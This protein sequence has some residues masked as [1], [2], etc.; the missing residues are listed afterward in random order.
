M[1]RY[2]YRPPYTLTDRIVVLCSRITEEIVKISITDSINSSP[3]LRRAN[4]VKTIQASLAIE[5]NTLSIEQVT[6]IVNGKRVLGSMEEICEVRNAFKAYE[7]VLSFDPYSVK[8]MLAAHRILM[9]D[10]TKEA[11]VFRSGGVGVFAGDRIVHMAPPAERV[12]ELIKELL[13]WLKASMDVH[14]LVRSCVFHYEFEFS[15][16]FSDGNGRMGRMW[17]TL[18]LSRWKP[19]FG[20]IPVETIIKERQEEYYRVLGECDRLADLGMFIEF[21]L[22]A[23]LDVIVALQE[24]VQVGV[25]VSDQVRRLLEVFDEETLSA[26]ELMERVQI[27]H[28]PTFRSNY[29]NPALDMGLI[30]MTVPDKPR[31]SKQRYRKA[32]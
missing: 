10:L 27:K 16:P 2:Q 12:P 11:G 29:L 5:N 32:I 31:S 21:I 24:T 30:E 22:Q 26:K 28:R 17:Q 18:L 9:K 25:Q 23:L 15:H 7:K 8:D 19:V 6:D 20:W 4:R 13:D 1:D 14:P 3:R